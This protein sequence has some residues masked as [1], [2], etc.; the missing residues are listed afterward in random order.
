MANNKSHATMPA[1]LSVQIHQRMSRTMHNCGIR[2]AQQPSGMSIKSYPPKA[3]F[4]FISFVSE[5]DYQSMIAS[6]KD[7]CIRSLQK[8]LGI[9]HV[10]GQS[11]PPLSFGCRRLRLKPFESVVQHIS[12]LLFVQWNT[13]GEVPTIDVSMQTQH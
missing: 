7:H 3:T 12:A 13:A 8:T 11:I 5:L 4:K 6:K 1:N 10:H 9:T 2:K